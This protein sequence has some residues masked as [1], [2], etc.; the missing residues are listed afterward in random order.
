MSQPRDS[1][2][3]LN[4]IHDIGAG[5]KETILLDKNER[6]TPFPKEF[7]NDFLKSLTPEDFIK[8]PDQS[9][10]YR[11]LAEFYHL[12]FDQILLVPG[13]DA[14]LKYIFET[15]SK[16]KNHVVHLQPTY[17]M[18]PVY[19]DMFDC[20]PVVAQ[21]H[22]DL[23]F[24]SETLGDQ[25]SLD[26]TLAIVANPNQPTGTLLSIEQLERLAIKA[27]QTNTL[28][29]IDEAYHDFTD[30]PSAISLIPRFQNLCVLK[31]FS[32]A[33]GLAGLRLGFLAAPHNI[34]QQ[35]IKV[36][37]LHDINSIAIAASLLLLDHYQIVDSYKYAIQDSMRKLSAACKKANLDFLPT[38]CNFAYVRIPHEV[39]SHELIATLGRQNFRVRLSNNTGTCLDGC[40]RFTVGPWEEMNSFFKALET[41]IE[42][43]LKKG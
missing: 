26:T 16:P 19:I 38:H 31:T 17:A 9:E 23:S 20:Q 2:L 3:S 37:P 12:E 43:S 10:L 6:I 4:R 13:S 42:D 15:Y 11:R 22:N 35:L 18:V 30:E 7:F 5:R 36:K 14:G 24:S 28:L 29:V 32:K 41:S 27:D 33:W 1:I 40:L 8:Y 34:T 25:L 21:F 39:D